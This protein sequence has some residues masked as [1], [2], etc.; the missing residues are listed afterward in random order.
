MSS[1]A[2]KQTSV[3]RHPP[4]ARDPTCYP[5]E[6]KV[7]VDSLQRLIAELLRPLL[8]RWYSALGKPTFVGADQF[9]YYK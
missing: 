4:V 7:G 3:P 5:V 8:E 1:T 9:I 6:G 2:M